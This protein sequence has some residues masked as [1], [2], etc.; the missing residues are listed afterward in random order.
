VNFHS[1]KIFSCQ[2]CLPEAGLIEGDI[3]PPSKD[4]L[5]VPCGLSVANEI[6][7]SHILK[8]L[9]L[10]LRLRSNLRLRL[11]LNY[12]YHFCM[13]KGNFVDLSFPFATERSP[14]MGN[15]LNHK[16]RTKIE[17]PCSDSEIPFLCLSFRS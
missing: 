7:G 15:V 10:R 16:S 4:L 5:P 6:D 11:C 12:P 9:R 8:S 14:S 17:I 2:F 3:R 13:D 1:L